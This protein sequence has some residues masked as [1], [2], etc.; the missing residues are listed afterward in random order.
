M[1]LA[2]KAKSTIE[3]CKT[4]EGF[5]ASADLYRDLWLRD[6]FY[7]ERT[8]I[9]LGYQETVREHFSTFLKYQLRSGQIPTVISS[10]R[11]KRLFSGMYHFWTSDTEILFVLG[12]T[13]YAKMTGDRA[14]LEENMASIGR[15]VKFIG[16]S[17]N[18]SGLLPGLDWRDAV[19]NY[20]HGPKYLLSNQVLLAQMYDELGRTEDAKILKETIRKL[21]FFTRSGPSFLPV[22]CV[23]WGDKEQGGKFEYRLDSLGNSL[24]ILFG[25][26][27]GD[28]AIEVAR[29]LDQARTNYGYRN[30]FPHM[31]I[32]RSRAFASRRAMAAFVRN[33]AFVRNRPDH[34]QNSALWPFVEARIVSAFRKVGFSQKAEEL[35]RIMTEREGFNEWYSPI[36]GRPH[37]SRDQLWTAA[38]V[39][40]Q[41]R[42]S[43]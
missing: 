41:Q 30:L 28:A 16:W 12:M 6:L 33:G 27:S 14:F 4:S 25:I 20:Y 18:S 37:G 8:L 17:L 15:C 23:S 29:N 13:T 21:F 19:V 10:T 7:S 3:K 31:R 1:T 35:S 32:E 39:L 5:T 42:Q 36:D 38:A 9:E 34:Y 22:D 26:V 40:D 43:L 24:A 11:W 2:A